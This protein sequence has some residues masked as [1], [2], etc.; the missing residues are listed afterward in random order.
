MKGLCNNCRFEFSGKDHE[1]LEDT[2]R[3]H[4]LMFGHSG[5]CIIN[6]D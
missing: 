5:F 1:E 2:F 3:S 4:G 6:Y